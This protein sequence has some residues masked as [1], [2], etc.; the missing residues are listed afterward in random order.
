MVKFSEYPAVI[1][2]VQY[3]IHELDIQIDRVY[4]IIKQIE[5]TV[6]SGIAFDKTLYNDAQRKAMK[7]ILLDEHP[8]LWEFQENISSLRAARE[9]KN[10]YLGKLRDE[11]SVWKLLKR[12]DI[13]RMESEGG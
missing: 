1:A 2:A 4:K 10:I 13:A 6:D 9:I 3:Q 12:E 7:Q 5:L 11:F 8:S